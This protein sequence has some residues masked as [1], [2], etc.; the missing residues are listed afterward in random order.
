MNLPVQW[1]PLN[2]S[3]FL[4]GTFNANGVYPGM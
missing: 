2:R 3:R 1:P 4:L